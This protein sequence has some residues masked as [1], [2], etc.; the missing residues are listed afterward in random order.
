M[1]TESTTEMAA[2]SVS[3]QA[4]GYP[5]PSDSGVPG[6]AGA[7][8]SHKCAVCGHVWE[9]LTAQIAKEVRSAV[10]ANK[11]GPFCGVCMHLEMAYRY[12]AFRGRADFQAAYRRAGGGV[13][14]YG[15][16]PRRTS[17]T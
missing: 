3:A 14:F 17:I 5:R 15:T 13:D 6:G 9:S 8:L 2:G 12:A 7:A 10:L 1:N 16:Q 4:D 11:Q